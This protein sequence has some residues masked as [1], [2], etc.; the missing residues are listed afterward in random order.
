MPLVQTSAL[1]AGGRQATLLPMLVHRVDDPVDA[2]IA[3]NRL[4]LWVDE[5][6]FEVFVGAVLVDPVAVEHAQ[7]GAA[8]AD[9]RLGGG[10]EGALV[11]ELV[12]TLVGWLACT[13]SLTTWF[14]PVPE[15]AQTICGT[16]WHW[17]LPP[18]SPHTHAVDDISLLGLVSQTLRLVRTRWLRRT[19][20]DVELTELD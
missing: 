1:L 2:G 19:V 15:I 6:D 12:H 3:A 17:P 18:T 10:F 9:T 4:V 11:F 8:T 20:D 14:Q 16:L 13:M 5:D 7:V